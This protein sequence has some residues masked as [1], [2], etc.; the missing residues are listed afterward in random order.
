MLRIEKEIRANRCKNYKIVYNI[1]R[2]QIKY[3]KEEEMEKPLLIVAS[4]V[5]HNVNGMLTTIPGAVRSVL[6]PQKGDKLEWEIYPDGS[7]K[8]KVKR[9]K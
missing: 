5:Q 3:E 6:K 7:V 9:E 8:V 1:I 4:S 2:R